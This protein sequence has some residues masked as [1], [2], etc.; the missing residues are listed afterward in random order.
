ML[1]NGHLGVVCKIDMEKA[2]DHV[3]WAFLDW[4]LHQMGFGVK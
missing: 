3:S 4:V 1:K 2:Y